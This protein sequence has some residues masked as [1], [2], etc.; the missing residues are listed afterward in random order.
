MKTLLLY[1]FSIIVSGAAIA[2]LNTGAFYSSR[3]A[4]KTGSASDAAFRDGLFLGRLDGA[5]GRKPHLASGRWAGDSDRRSFVAAY[6]QGYREVQA[7]AASRQLTLLELVEQR[8]YDDGI[9]DG[10]RQR[11]QAGTFHATGTE[12]YLKAD[13]GDVEGSDTLEQYTKAY[14]E[15]YCE[16]YQLGYYGE[17]AMISDPA[18]VSQTAIPAQ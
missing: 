8:G 4:V 3:M 6:L 11:S 14:R 2:M 7:P 10:I 13:Y 18:H 12:H 5:R 16:A 1:A 9:A 17:S 15:A